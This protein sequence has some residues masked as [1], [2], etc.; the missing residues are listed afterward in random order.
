MSSQPRCTGTSGLG[1]WQGLFLILGRR[2]MTDGERT[3]QP[4]WLLISF[5]GREPRV[6]PH[7]AALDFLANDW[8]DAANDRFSAT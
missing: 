8:L 6:L 5:K 7:R 4:G 3:E 1:R 2:A